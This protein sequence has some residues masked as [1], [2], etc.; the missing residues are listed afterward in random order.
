VPR[1]GDAR[2]HLEAGEE[3]AL[4]GLR[5]LTDLDFKQVAGVFPALS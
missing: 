3:S 2:R 1:L 4:A 5:A